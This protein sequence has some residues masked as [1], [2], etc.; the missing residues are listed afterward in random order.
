MIDNKTLDAIKANPESVI[1]YV[2]RS[3]F[4]TFARYVKPNLQ[5]TN[6]HKVY[7]EVLNRFAHK[8]IRKLIV[9]VPPQ[10]GKSEASSRLLPAFLIGLNP[11]YKIVICSYRYTLL[12]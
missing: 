2:A 8:Q 4:V 9:S 3:R 5:M 12:S 10:H 6:F 7:Y 11:D 1:R